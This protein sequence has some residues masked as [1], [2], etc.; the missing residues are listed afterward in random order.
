MGGSIEGRV[1]EELLGRGKAFVR[2]AEICSGNNVLWPL[3]PVWD[4]SDIERML[5]TTSLTPLLVNFQS[6][7]S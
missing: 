7:T 1:R 2:P 4:Y 6:K 3:V 5:A